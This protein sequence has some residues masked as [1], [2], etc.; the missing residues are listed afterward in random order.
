M[1]ENGRKVVPLT[2]ADTVVMIF[3]D[4]GSSKRGLM[5]KRIMDHDK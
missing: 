3:P 4:K 5:R 1:P 2:S